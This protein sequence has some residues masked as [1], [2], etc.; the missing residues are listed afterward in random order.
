MYEINTR[1]FCKTN[2]WKIKDFLTNGFLEAPEIQAADFLWLMGVWKPSQASIDISLTHE[3]LRK[4]FLNALPD[5]KKEDIIGSPYAVYDYEP[6]S[7]IANNFEEIAE[8]RE[9]LNTEGKKLILDFVPNHVSVD[10]VLLKEYPNA[11]LKKEGNSVCQNSFLHKNG[12]IYFH[13]RDPYFDGWTDTVQWDF[14]NPDV[15]EIHIEIL[16]KIAKVCDGVRCD[17]AMLPMETVFYKTHGKHARPYWN[18]LIP[19]IRSKNKDFVF[20]A[21][22]YWG[23]EY[24]LQ[25]LGFQFTYD[26]ELYDRLKQRDARQIKGHLQAELSYQEKS[27]RFIENHDEDRA[28]H[29][30]QVNSKNFFSLL[31]FLPGM[32]LYYESQVTGAEKKLPVQLGRKSE[33]YKEDIDLFYKRCFERIIERKN[34]NLK[35]WQSELRPYSHDNLSDVIVYVLL[36]TNSNQ[37]HCSLELLIFN[38]LP[39]EIVGCFTLTGDILENIIQKDKQKL[40]FLDLVNDRHYTYRLE[41]VSKHGIYIKLEAFQSHWFVL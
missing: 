8:F 25:Q 35:L 12:T 28:Y 31:T 37:E 32:I 36:E 3:G 38:T 10:T 21:E 22:V 16:R 26:K 27:L 19:N 1:V 15:L 4:D 41:D 23:M 13:G 29:I 14:S 39:R 7:L 2:F 9:K 40:K 18:K 20:I 5:L 33:E 17:M 30:F 11:F 34:Y 24:D 6:N